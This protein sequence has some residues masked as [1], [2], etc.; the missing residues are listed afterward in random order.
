MAWRII[1]AN[2]NK[3]PR[4]EEETFHVF[5]SSLIVRQLLTLNNYKAGGVGMDFS[6]QYRWRGGFCME[7]SPIPDTVVIF[8]ALGDLANRKLI[9]SLFNLHRRGL[10]HEKSAIV[11]CGRA[12]M[13]QDAY[14]E[15]V[16]KLLSEK[17]PPDRQELIETFLKKL[18]YHAGDYGEDDTYTRLDAQLKEIEHSFSNDNACRIYYLS[19]A[20]SVYLTVVN[21]LCQAGLLAEDPVTNM[22]WRHVV[23]EKPFGRDLESAKELD[24]NLR[25]CLNE[26]Q[27]YRI[28][29]YLGKETVQNILMF[30]FANLIFEP[31][32]N[33]DYIDSVQ[34]TVA[35]TVGVEHRAKYFETAGLLRDMFQNHMFEMLSLVAME[36]PASFEASSVR[37]E[38]AK[39]LRSIRPFNLEKLNE[40]MIRAQYAEGNGMAAY[41]SEPGVAPESQTETYV[42]A[43]LLIDNWR[44]KGVPF[45]LRSGKRLAAKRSE[46]VI[47]FKHIPHSIFLP[48][49]SEDLV[50][51][52]LTLTVQ[53]QEGLSLSFLAKKPGPKLCMGDLTMDFKY[54]SILEKG[55]SMPEAY[56]RL[57][58]DCMLGDQTLFIRSDTVEL[59]WGLLTPV[60]EHWKEHPESCPL[61][62]YP[63]GS[64]GPKE[65][66]RLIQNDNHFWTEFSV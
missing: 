61:A 64:S 32:W 42:A 17:N 63:A 8:G 20:P 48:V 14:R 65:A 27:I 47:T 1:S 26:R 39:L 24:R 7:V 51:N 57:L 54:A 2:T 33:R 15:T 35:E 55:E 29:H 22:P 56:E 53:P 18:F 28:D 44:W 11:A 6:G 46:I 38:K 59:A 49:H 34:I 37:D 36:V 12:P 58:L 43:K 30:R 4:E 5:S 40:Q 31:V 60:L 23:I 41:R 50:Q 45:Y 19:T 66:D 62:F 3:L 21:H 10:F 9:P 13:E 16:R 25:K 52:R